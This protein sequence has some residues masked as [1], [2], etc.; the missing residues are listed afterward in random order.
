MTLKTG[1][2]AYLETV[3]WTEVDHVLLD[4]DGTL[5]DLAFDNDFWGQRI[6]EKYALLHEISIAQAVAKF[7]PLFKSVAGT[8]SWYST[9]FWSQQYG[10]NVIEHSRAYAVEIR[11]LPFAKEFLHALR[12]SDVRSTIVTNAHPDIVRLKH[13]ITGI[14]DLV[15]RTISSHTLGHAKESP[16]FWRQLQPELKFNPAST[17]FFDDSPAVLSA[18]IDFG[19]ERSIAIC[20]PDSTRPKCIPMSSLAVNNFEQLGASLRK[21]GAC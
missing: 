4:M 13:E 11:W 12:E 8:L 16:N 19:I 5:L 17:L 1:S 10:Y 14:T 3:D 21:G 20:H 18:A 9:D 15:D 2:G 6:H 7:E